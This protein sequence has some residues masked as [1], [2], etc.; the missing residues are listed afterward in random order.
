MEFDKYWMEKYD[1]PPK[2]GG[3]VLGVIR[4]RDVNKKSEKLSK[5]KEPDTWKYGQFKA[6]VQ[7]FAYSRYVCSIN[8]S[9]GKVLSHKVTALD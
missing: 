2:D 3:E 7:E 5:L 4:A 1:K 8:F 6:M 9:K